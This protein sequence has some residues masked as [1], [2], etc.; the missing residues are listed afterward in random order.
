MQTAVQPR[1]GS[2]QDAL[3]QA[4][5]LLRT[6]SSLALE[7]AQ[8][9]LKV[10]PDEPRA[11]FLQGQAFAQMGR[12]QEAV[13]ALRRAAELEP[14]GP[15]WRAL[16][17]QLTLLDDAAGADAAYA[18]SI[19]AS[20]RDPR[21]MHAA[22]ALCEGKLAV[23]EQLLR[24]RL[25]AT[26][27][28]VAAIRMLAEVGARLGRF[29]DAEKLLRRCLE[30]APSFHAARHNYAIVLHRESKSD[31]ALKQLDLLLRAEPDNPSYQFLRAAA[32]ARIGE[33]EAAIA[34]YRDVLARYPNSARGWLSLG[35]ACKT[36][37]LRTESIAA[38][39][40]VVADAP[41]FGE[42]YW[43][44]ANLKTHPFDDA[45]VARMT[46]Q[47]ERA[48][49]GDEDRFHIH[50]ALGKAYEDKQQF[51]QSFAH[52]AAGARIR[53]TGLD[54]KADETTQ[55]ARDHTALFTRAFFDSRKGQ[56]AASSDPIFI[57]GL[58]RSGST[59]IE[60]ILASHSMVEGTMELPDII[61]M[62]KRLGGGK[63]RGGSYP[64][65][66]AEL[67]PEQI[68]ALGEEYIAR[69]RVQRKTDRPF[70]IDKMPNNSQHV[71]FIHLILPNAKIIDARR[72]PM[73]ACFSAFKQHFA[74]GQ[75]FTY[76]LADVGR[77]YSDYVEMMARFEAAAPGRVHRVLY[78]DMIENT[79]AE[80]RRLLSYLG[81][82]F[83]P[84]CLEFYANK[85]AVRTAS[86]EQVRQQIYTGAVEQWRHYEPW[87]QPL[88][89][90]LGSTIDNYPRR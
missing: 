52:Y 21:L 88:K 67:S 79:E 37:G 34:I 40:Q 2:I 58:P 80:V 84:A 25:R 61:A 18:Q 29:E 50:Y 39:E 20:V 31:E 15:A 59:L 70:F 86:S 47:L 14:E 49:L 11:H 89:T 65:V 46:R 71:G 55:A 64:G 13:A 60:Q 5:A 56:G 41:H 6:N 22:I 77:Y 8:E 4:R 68:K 28:D 44:L 53:R 24:E 23:A 81:L 42:A 45:A 57:V 30:L 19:R 72:H 87:L 75:A 83:E 32:L 35:H 12:H 9:I 27:T 78:E 33:Y 66:L 90:A 85:R 7:Q 54:Y 43:S 36:A 17:D 69:T 16:G 3:H 38:Y 48:D 63:V 1:T 10:H 76:D 26:P 82:P 51:E 73:A 62:A 74:R